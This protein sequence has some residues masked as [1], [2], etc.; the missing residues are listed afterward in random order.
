MRRR[1]NVEVVA[2]S[3]VCLGFIDSGRVSV[4]CK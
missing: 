2:T 1:E 4:H 3:D